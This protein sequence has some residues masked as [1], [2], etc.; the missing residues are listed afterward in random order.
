[1]YDFGFV[2]R[3][4]Q[5]YIGSRRAPLDLLAF[6]GKTPT[7]LCFLFQNS[8]IGWNLFKKMAR[9]KCWVEICSEGGEYLNVTAAI[10][11]FNDMFFDE[12]LVNTHTHSLALGE[13]EYLTSFFNRI[14]IKGAAETA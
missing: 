1:M 6:L 4:V 14:I 9:K 13:F 2:K 3:T 7:D 8:Q 11:L 5:T 10:E 12:T